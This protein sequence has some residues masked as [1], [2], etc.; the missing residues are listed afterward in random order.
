MLEACDETASHVELRETDT[1]T[2]LR[3]SDVLHVV[4]AG[5]GPQPWERAGGGT[6]IADW[7]RR[8]LAGATADLVV[9]SELALTP[10]FSVTRD[11]SW[12]EGGDP[13]DGPEL[14]AVAEAAAELGCYVLAAFA[15]R[16]R[17][18]GVLYNSAALIGPD[19]R[20]REGRYC[21]GPT[22]GEATRVYR[23][24]H[25]SENWNADPGVHEK[26]F[27]RPGDGFVVYETAFGRFAPL[28]CYDRSFP[29]SWRAVRLAGARV[30]G[31]AAAFSRPERVKTFELE[32][33]VAAVQNGVFVVAASK[34]GTE[35]SE[36]GAA[37]VAFAGGSCVVS[38][39]GDVLARGEIGDGAELVPYAIDLALIDEHDRTYHVLR[40]RRPEAY[41]PWA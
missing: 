11:R 31:V 17:D 29:E 30:I 18:S 12:L 8:S 34:R 1:L 2:S 28:I 16:D 6:R 35:S 32:L 22:A 38:P 40:D 10:F 4:A 41:R 27:F 14:G 3:G 5:C 19:G 7:L 24:V 36:D 21:T 39:F 9:L 20:L 37:S 15:E 26:Y 25:L 33:Q 23:K 13:L